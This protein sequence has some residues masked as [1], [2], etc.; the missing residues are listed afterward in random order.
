MDISKLNPILNKES[1]L[2]TA[3]ARE[4]ERAPQ[5]VLMRYINYS[6]THVPL[7]DTTRQLA[8]LQR[9]ITQN[10]TCAVGTIVGPYGYGK[11]STAVHIWSELREKRIMAVP[12]F[13]WNNLAQLIDAVY[14]W[15]RFEF[16][17]GPKAFVSTLTQ[18]RDQY[19]GQRL[20][21]LQRELD[22]DTVQK[23]ADQGRLIL[24][25]RPEDVLGFFDATAKLCLDAGYEGLAI[26]TD[27]LQ[28]TVAAYQPSRD[29]FYADFFQ[30]VKDILG[31]PGQ[32]AL[33]VTMDDGTEGI[34][35]RDR[36]DMLQRMQRSAIYFRVKDVYNRREYP[37]E[38]WQAFERRFGFAGNEVIL[39]ET[40]EAIGQVAARE[41]LGAGPRMVTYA[42]SLAAKHYGK[43]GNAYAPLQFVDDFLDGQ[44]VFDQRGKFV[45]ALR[46]SLENPN[47][48]TQK[49]YQE[50]VK[51]LAA[52]PM[53]CEERTL[54][55]FQLLGAFQTFPPLA[56]RELVLQIAGGYILRLMAEEE[57]EPE[58]V[59]QQLI[60]DFANRFA[61]NNKQFVQRA[62]DGFLE[63]I[64][65]SPLFADWDRKSASKVNVSGVYYSWVLLIGS[66][67]SQ[68]PE[69][70]IVISVAAVSQ[71]SQPDWRKVQPDA[72]LE[73]RFELNT[74]LAPTE[75]NRLIVAPDLPNVAVFQLNLRRSDADAAHKIL[76]EF[77]HD[78]YSPD[79]LTPLL[80]LALMDHLIKNVGDLPDDKQ[81]VN[82][83]M[84][85]L[86]QYSLSL[87]FDSE[88][89]VSPAD[90]TS[91]MVG[92]ERIKDLFRQIVRTMYPA[93]KTLMISRKWRENLQQYNYAIQSVI[94]ED[95]L[96]IA[97]GRRS[98][99]AGKEEVADAFR[100]PGRRLTNLESLLDVLDPLIEKEDF[101]GRR[102]DST[103]SLKFHLHPLELEWLEMIDES[104]EK[105]HT[106][107]M[108]V[109]AI[110][111]EMLVRHA[112][113]RGYTQSEIGEVLRLLQ[114]RKFVDYDQ[115]KNLIIR[116]VDAIDDLRDTVATQIAAF[117]LEVSE[118][119][120][121]IPDFEAERYGVAQIQVV[122][123]NAT[124]RD[125]IEE[126]SDQLRALS[127]SLRTFVASRTT[128]LQQ[129]I[130]EDLD[131][132][133]R[134]IDQ[135]VPGWLSTGFPDNPIQEILEKQRTSMVSDYQA[136]LNELQGL[137]STANQELR[138]VPGTA[139]GQVI[140]LTRALRSITD[141]GKKL[142]RRLEAYD[143]RKD[144]MDNWRKVAD[145]ALKVDRKAHDVDRKYGQSQF[146]QQ[147]DAFWS[148]V[149]TKADAEPLA[150]MGMYRRTYTLVK[151][152]SDELNQWLDGRR[153]EFE[154]RCSEYEQILGEVGIKVDLKIPFDSDNPSESYSALTRNLRRSLAQRLF[155]MR[156]ELRRMRQIIRYAIQVQ[157]LPL[158][159]AD[160]TTNDVEIQLND[161]VTRVENVAIDDV[162]LFRNDVAAPLSR[163]LG[164]YGALE[165][166][167]ASAVQRRTPEG[168]EVRLLELMNSNAAGSQIDLRGLIISML[169]Q[170]EE[171]VDLDRII[172]DLR[173]LFQ[174]NQVSI[175]IGLV[176]Q[177]SHQ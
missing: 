53:G 59:E 115:R 82:T 111:A 9:V 136:T 86:R 89:D 151:R 32:W 127:A 27:E 174:K 5:D 93:Y 40:L 163:L 75:P 169:D 109:P 137:R 42:L 119:A 65:L 2:K 159:T 171:D 149:R 10:K 44:M 140:G 94:N 126:I 51:L 61:P 66:F 81:R 100:I 4:L 49:E 108:E 135:G 121:T 158:Q 172:Y 71:S 91:H 77:L 105:F 37:A 25:I 30:I 157:G 134:I 168:S 74:S 56:R 62:A 45:T 161:L 58:Q 85:P 130:R 3:N 50:V 80:T 96:S 22:A 177:R 152:L 103:V 41:D 113:Y 64:L 146:V 39:P 7:G 114:T 83:V 132:I 73:F 162:S 67:D 36:A 128:L 170:G 173:S 107:G 116:A 21:D 110:A 88:M 34:I 38:L 23:L 12:P 8:N 106:N 144:D 155:D 147:I 57:A 120:K 148:D 125:E 46:K 160:E 43:T 76:P 17:Q 150:V 102:A 18:A 138:S 11:T 141:E 156:N 15:V 129:K 20:S 14:H 145:F 167:V 54:D 78:Y 97:R 118:I 166:G 175:T 13:Q 48:R 68:Y 165:N 99:I 90:Y 154:R 84:L 133:S 117:S 92:T 124:E 24:D 142:R 6:H 153:S 95:G 123:E 69:R 1:I 164:N 98:W 31:L 79:K 122:L 112:Q 104:G 26:F 72:E 33:V 63:Q 19:H 55:R 29:Q 143:D 101:S 52:Y 87:L 47:V 35:A 60:K 139:A 16:E 176:S 131:T 70:T 28:A